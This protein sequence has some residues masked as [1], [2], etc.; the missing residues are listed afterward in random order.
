MFTFEAHKDLLT[1]GLVPNIVLQ[2]LSRALSYIPYCAILRWW[3]SLLC[4]LLCLDSI[5]FPF[6]LL[7]PRSSL[8]C[9]WRSQNAAELFL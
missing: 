7:H 5:D 4:V 9:W 3:L 6:V 2:Q 1:R 8:L